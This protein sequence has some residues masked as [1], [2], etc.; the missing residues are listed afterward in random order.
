MHQKRH[1]QSLLHELHSLRLSSWDLHLAPCSS[2]GFPSPKP[3]C[4]ADVSPV[5]GT[6][7]CT[8]TYMW[9][10]KDWPGTGHYFPC[11]PGCAPVDTAQGAA[12]CP[13]SQDILLAPAQLVPAKVPCPLL[14]SCSQ[15][16]R[17]QPESLHGLIPC[18]MQDLT[19][20]HLKFLRLLCRPI[21]TASLSLSGWWPCP[22]EYQ[23]VT[24]IWCHLQTWIQ[25]SLLFLAGIG[26]EIKQ[27]R[28]HDTSPATAFQV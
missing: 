8:V 16:L 21:S 10:N 26:K 19:S 11:C 20:V 14:Q 4:F 25:C 9:L 15:P 6:G 17:H 24:L 3:L 22:Q 27:D 28:S 1:H 7:M 12:G 5:S 23:L 13:F 2:L 18:Q